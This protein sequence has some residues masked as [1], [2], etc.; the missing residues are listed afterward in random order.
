MNHLIPLLKDYIN[1]LLSPED[2]EELRRLFAKYPDLKKTT[3]E[4]KSEEGLRELLLEY[5]YIFDTDFAKREED[6][7]NYILTHIRAG[8]IRH[9]RPWFRYAIV[10]SIMVCL[11]I[12]GYILYPLINDSNHK[13]EQFS[14]AIP[15]G[16]NKAI[17]TLANGE[18]IL[19]SSEHQGI[20]I[21]NEVRYDGGHT[22]V[23]QDLVA[24]TQLL[25]R[26]PR[27]GQ[28]HITLSDGTKVWLN[29][30]SKLVYPVTFVGDRREVY[31]EGEGY[32][33]VAS[34]RKKP[35]I[36]KTEKEQVEVLGTHFN[37]N[38][39]TDERVSRV[40]LLE[41]SVKVSTAAG[42]GSEILRPGQQSLVSSAGISV[43]A[44][45]MDECL[46]W[47]NGEFMFNNESLESIA[48]R[49]ERWYDIDIELSPRIKNIVIWGAVSRYEDF[50]TVME[51]IKR[52]DKRITYSM[53][54]RRTVVMK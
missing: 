24:R 46:A 45:D 17:L 21:D 42:R 23:N 41:G 13:T 9:S 4:L 25:L 29:A 2:N 38:S 6:N 19:L 33:E 18:E 32:F 52:T 27:G 48:R 5:E 16:N 12:G 54:G 8:D 22:I 3:D 36:V 15:A 7:L 30:E 20:I 34:D 35:F 11:G 53:Q 40:A 26:T 31:L 37:L 49:L 14:G 43:E 28:Y 50:D 39:Y 44:V 47:K 10:A 51:V 1:G